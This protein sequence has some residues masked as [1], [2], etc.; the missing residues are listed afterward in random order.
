MKNRFKYLSSEEI[1]ELLHGLKW[2]NSEDTELNIK[3]NKGLR[4]ELEERCLI[5]NV[6]E[7]N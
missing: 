2:S 6:E 3:V 4:D 7:E 5:N 1:E